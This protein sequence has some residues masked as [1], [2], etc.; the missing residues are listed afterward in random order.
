MGCAEYGFCMASCLKET[1]TEYELCK[2]AT[3]RGNVCLN[4]DTY[5]G[6][7]KM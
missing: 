7:L 3:E 5:C 6:I 2:K 1:E 4:N